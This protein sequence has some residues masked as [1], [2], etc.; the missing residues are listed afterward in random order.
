MG[1]R[2]PAVAGTFYPGSANALRRIVTALLAAVPAVRAPSPKALVV[3]HAGYVYSGPIAASAYARLRPVR[4]L[5]RRVV[6]LGPAHRVPVSGLATSGSDT[7]DTPLGSVPLDRDVIERLERLPQV[8][9]N[10]RAHA[11]EHSLEVQLPFLQIVLERFSLVPLVVGEASDRDVEEVLRL[12]WGGPET[13]VVV[14]SDLSH[15]LEYES[16]RRTDGETARAILALAADRIGDD[17]ACGRVPVRGLLARAAH[18]NLHAE[19]LDLRSSGDTAGS[20]DEVV[21]Y[22]AFAF[23]A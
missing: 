23:F 10:D 18:Q 15:Y 19:Q 21:G 9:R 20:K 3:P 8:R 11:P 12:A 4:E 2:P 13:L 1:A 6:L 14:S 22:G 7:F 16:A 17:R 5:V